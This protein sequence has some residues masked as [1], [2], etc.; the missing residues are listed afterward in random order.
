MFQELK[1]ICLVL[2]MSKPPASI[3][4]F[5]FFTGIEKK[6]SSA[7]VRCRHYETGVVFVFDAA[8]WERFCRILSAL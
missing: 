8:L 4:M 1:A 3:T 2:G 5:Q 6:V 7:I